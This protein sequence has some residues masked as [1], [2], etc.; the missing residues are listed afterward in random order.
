[1]AVNLPGWVAIMR[2]SVIIIINPLRSLT[3]VFSSLA[4]L[5]PTSVVA[6][7]SGGDWYP[8]YFF[9]TCP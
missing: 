2:M 7:A 4:V 9:I 1:M 5:D 6:S 3:L 8:Q